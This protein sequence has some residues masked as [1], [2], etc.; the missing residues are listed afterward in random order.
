MKR[1]KEVF[2]GVFRVGMLDAFAYRG[3]L[4]VWFLATTMPLVMFLLWGTA[5]EGRTLSG[6]D[7]A[8]FRGYF[9]AA[10]L[11]REIAGSWVAY[12]LNMD[13]KDGT[14][15]L[16]LLRPLHPLVHYVVE[17]IAHIPFRAALAFPLVFV[18]FAFDSALHLPPA[19]S[20]A[21]FAVSVVLG[22]LISFFVNVLIASL[23]FVTDQSLKVLDLWTALFFAFSGYLV[24]QALLPTWMQRVLLFLP[25]RYQMGVPV[26]ILT[27]SLH[28]QELVRTLAMQG[29]MA[30]AVGALAFACFGRGVGRFEA[31]GG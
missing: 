23:A 10:F 19:F 18:I 31:Y 15:S 28:G 4:I 29:T 24:P 25:F 12:Q 13:I 9:L 11:V 20:I 8:A 22:F 2:L 27:G 3:E 17:Q 6:M 30:L 7:A 21:C 5:A 26:E 14:L 1:A 16:R